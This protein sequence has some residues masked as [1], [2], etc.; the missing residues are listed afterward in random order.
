MNEQ[1]FL[2]A[3]QTEITKL[4]TSVNNDVAWFKS[5]QFYSGLI[6]GGIAVL[7]FDIIVHLL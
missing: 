3:L 2:T 6:L 4:N 1:E 5:H 7:F